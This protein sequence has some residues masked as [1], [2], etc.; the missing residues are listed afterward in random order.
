MIKFYIICSLVLIGCN[1]KKRSENLTP[2]TEQYNSNKIM[3]KQDSIPFQDLTFLNKE[4]AI[5]KYGNPASSEQFILDDAQG[6]FRNGLSDVFTAKERQS[7]S[8]LIDEV[9]WE[10]DNDTWI[11]V[12]YQKIENFKKV[13]F[14]TTVTVAQ[15]R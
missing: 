8:I 14:V 11:T 7:E 2:K 10:K 5:K 15:P 12:W 1:D 13:L 6:E 4:E 9:T 3:K